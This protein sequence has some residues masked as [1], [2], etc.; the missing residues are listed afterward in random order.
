MPSSEV[1]TEMS[2]AP[3]K[4]TPPGGEVVD[5]ARQSKDPVPVLG[6]NRCVARLRASVPNA[7]LILISPRPWLVSFMLLRCSAAT[8]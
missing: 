8:T 5:A 6:A 1:R 3:V 4:V 7:L 2:F